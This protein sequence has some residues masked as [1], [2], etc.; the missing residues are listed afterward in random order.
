MTAWSAHNPSVRSSSDAG[1][2]G[3]GTVSSITVTRRTALLHEARPVP[4]AAEGRDEADPDVP[5]EAAV[6][7]EP[8]EVVG[9]V[10]Q[11]VVVDRVAALVDG[12][13]AGH[14]RRI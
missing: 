7:G 3:M 4:D 8:V 9:L 2:A 12:I 13:D 11:R 5:A 10:P 1:L 14:R 6:V